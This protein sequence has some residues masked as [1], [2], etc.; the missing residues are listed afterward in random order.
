[1]S[2]V[3]C[4]SGQIGS[5]KSSISMAVAS[6]LGWARVGFGEYLRS[7]IERIGGDPEARKALQ[8]LGQARVQSNA[9]KFCRDVLAFG[10][11]VAGDN[12]VVDGIRH[13]EIYDILASIG[14]PSHT[15]L[16]F[17]E[18]QEKTRLSRIRVRDDMQD[19]MRASVHPV[20]AELQ[21][22]LPD[23]ADGVVDASQPFERVVSDC[24]KLAEVWRSELPDSST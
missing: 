6:T 10:G 17:L 9:T 1:M 16:L 24:L 5:G 4:F 23:R 18:A 2:L 8:E 22:Q 7:E 11:Y 20:E 3:L 12:F 19:F 14:A 13:L 21:N 15:R